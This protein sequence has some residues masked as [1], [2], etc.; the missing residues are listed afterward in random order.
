MSRRT[1]RKYDM[2]EH[3]KR[4]K[5]YKPRIKLENAPPVS[6]IKD[7]IQIGKSIR[8]YKNLDTIMLWRITPYLEQLDNMVGMKSLKETVFYQV[9]YY[10]QNMH[11]RNQNEE[12]LHTI[13]CGPP[14]T[15]KCLAKNTPVLMYNGDIKKVQNIKQGE[16]IMGDDSSPRKILNTC[17]GKEKMYRINQI[18][19]DSYTVNESHILSLKLSKNPKYKDNKTKNKI[20]VEWFD[21]ENKH[22]KDFKYTP[23][24][25]I[26]IQEDAKLFTKNLPN[27]GHVIDISVINY[28]KRS[29]DWK[30]VFK[31]YKTGVNFPSKEVPLDPYHIGC[32]SINTEKNKYKKNLNDI[33]KSYSIEKN[34]IPKIYKINDEKTRLEFLA[35]MIDSEGQVNKE[36][37]EIVVKNEIFATDIIYLTR[38]LG[39]SAESKKIGTFHSINIF[40]DIAK[41]PTRIIRN[42][43][44]STLNHLSYQIS[45][46]E[47]EV[48]DYFG[49]EIDGNKRFLLGD[50]TVTHNTTVAKILGK[51]YQAIG[52]LSPCGPFKIAYRDDFVAE[53]LGQTAV[54]TRKLLKSCIGGVLFIDEVY[55]LAPRQSD[56]DSFSDEALDTLTS[57]LSEHKNDFCCIAAGYEEDIFS[58]VFTKNKGLERRFPWVHK[59]EEYNSEE[60]A[61]IMLKMVSEMKWEV[62]TDKKSIVNVIEKNKKYFKRAG[63]DI[64]TFLSKCKMTHAKRVI[65]LDKEHK[66]VITVKDMENALDLIKKQ[67]QKLKQEDKP[68]PGMYM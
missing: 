3:T 27:I 52:I 18:Y 40:G 64:E 19:G 33:L 63:G 66:F 55:S 34:R 49:F 47:L 7:L 56:R 68:P 6:S 13:I 1:K 8:F 20:T 31:G 36:S 46:T 45:I 4:D 48:D 25:K 59:I 29:N 15:G 51:I 39:L 42:K 12:Y 21:Y 28:L 14:G 24:T 38:S 10:L 35:G 16:L 57:F 9:I 58:R 65:S 61:N 43:A 50:F 30:N 62:G 17:Q 23:K 60:L 11:S 37:Y 22:T 67:K 54:K 26:K 5:R 2:N 32:L 53:Y 41:I 44:K